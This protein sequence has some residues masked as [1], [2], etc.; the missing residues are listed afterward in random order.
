M[1]GLPLLEAG[2]PV[3]TERLIDLLWNDPAPPRPARRCMLRSLVAEKRMLFLLDNAS[4]AD[5]IRPLLP[6]SL[7]CVVLVTSRNQLTGLVAT[8]GAHS[9][10]LGLLSSADSWQL[11]AGRLGH[12]R[13]QAEPQAV[14]RLIELCA[15]LPLALAVAA[16]R[17]A[18]QPGSRGMGRG[19]RWCR[20]WRRRLAG[21][22]AQARAVA[23]R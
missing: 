16:A 1:L 6:G 21:E 20:R 13:M 22:P 12:P 19:G 14:A 8:E 23:T 2:K 18:A 15:G 10:T 4:D 17:A 5:Q 11:L 9:L 7:G 3:A